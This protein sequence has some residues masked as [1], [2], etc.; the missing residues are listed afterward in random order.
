MA[1]GI[2]P[3]PNTSLSSPP[4]GSNFTLMLWARV[5][6]RHTHLESLHSAELNFFESVILQ[7]PIF[8]EISVFSPLFLAR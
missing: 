4:V 5:L 7:R 1:I 6:I 2:L 3:T 8:L